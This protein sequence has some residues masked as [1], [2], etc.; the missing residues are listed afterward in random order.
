MTFIALQSFTGE[1]SMYVGEVRFVPTT[2]PNYA[3]YL[4]LL[5]EGYLAEYEGNLPAVSPADVGKVLTVNAEGAWV[6]TEAQSGLPEITEQDEG[7][8]LRV[9]GGEAMWKL[10]SFY[11]MVVTMSS[12]PETGE[13]VFSTTT[14]PN[15]VLGA[16]TQGKDV[17]I[18]L[19]YGIYKFIE[20]IVSDF[21]GFYDNNNEIIGYVPAPVP[22]KYGSL[23]TAINMV[24][25]TIT[26]VDQAY[27]VFVHPLEEYHAPVEI[28]VTG[29]I[30]T[31]TG[32]N[33]F[34]TDVTPL[35]VGTAVQNGADKVKVNIL[36][37]E[38]WGTIASEGALIALPLTIDNGM[39]I[40]IAMVA[41]GLDNYSFVVST[42]A[43]TDIPP[44]Q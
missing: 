18:T 34:A 32:T 39:A 27:N 42:W 15:D 41:S 38:T 40:Y 17:V 43:V 11:P 30:D 44:A 9:Y 6:A 25:F 29:A 7:L 8:P 33:D 22:F 37:Y 23:G 35:E 24:E 26:A 16:L 13:N 10:P 36:G 12:D 5:N 2:A 20:T 28:Q 3:D 19:E 4:A 31:S 21:I 14:T 1:I